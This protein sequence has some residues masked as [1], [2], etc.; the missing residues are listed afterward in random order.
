MVRKAAIL[1]LLVALT[2]GIWTLASPRQEY[3]AQDAETFDEF[4]GRLIR[5]NAIPGMAV[6]VISDRKIAH[7]GGYGFAD[8]ESNRPM[9]AETPVNIAS[10]SK[11]ILGLAILQLVD[12]G[13]LEL[14][15][16]VNGYLPFEIV[17]PHT[18]GEAITLRHL[19]THTS[20][21]ADFYDVADFE[22]GRDSPTP[23]TAHLQDLLTAS[24]ERYGEGQHFL[25]TS[26][27][28]AREYSNLGAGVAGAVA[29]AKTGQSLSELSRTGVFEPLG[30]KNTSWSLGDYEPGMLAKRYR[31]EQCLPWTGICTDTQHPVSN[32]IV[33]AVFDPPA[34]S[35][36][37]L[38]Y[39][40]FGN[41]NY[42]DGGVHSSAADLAKLAI[43]LLNGGQ[44]EDGLILEEATFAEMMRLQ[45]PPEVSTR[46][47]FFWRDRDGMTGHSGSDL[48]VYSSFYFDMDSGNAVIVLMNR[49]PDAQTELA[50]EQVIARAREDFD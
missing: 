28:T 13:E 29:E 26:P 7:S 22:P 14:D 2:L 15:E 45:L 23:L 42:P 12:Q 17:N 47:R 6:A 3:T 9:T 44:Y 49:T 16:D 20:G 25:E 33:G 41:P 5:E 38:A 40:Q 18:Q 37:Y 43:A 30:M 1:F 35:K 24:G 34:Q 36:K 8:V 46:Q 39:S 19:A 10:V 11:P 21:I 50:M 4:A 48:G 32:H 27:G 31:V